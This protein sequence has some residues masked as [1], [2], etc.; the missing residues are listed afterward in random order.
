MKRLNHFD[1]SFWFWEGSA[2]CETCENAEGTPTWKKSDLSRC[3]I[4]LLEISH[5][6]GSS[7]VLWASTPE[8]KELRKC[9]EFLCRTSACVVIMAPMFQTQVTLLFWVC[10][11]S[12]NNL[13][14]SSF[15]SEHD[16]QVTDKIFAEII[17]GTSLKFRKNVQI[18][19]QNLVN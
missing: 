4:I 7:N 1:D 3:F 18:M 14:A 5:C 13:S 16:K 10:F 6:N 15:T 19:S 9:S 12:V 17:S 11:I 2:F 8:H